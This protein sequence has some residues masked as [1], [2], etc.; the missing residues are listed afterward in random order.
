MDHDIRSCDT[1][2]MV[3]ST[4]VYC[5]TYHDTMLYYML[6][7]YIRYPIVRK[8]N[9]MVWGMTWCNFTQYHWYGMIYQCIPWHT[10][11]QG[12][13]VWYNV[14]LH[15]IMCY[16]LVC[17]SVT[18]KWTLMQYTMIWYILICDHRLHNHSSKHIMMQHNTL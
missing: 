5:G 2:A 15:C 18:W 6:W 7:H 16:E 9:A 1:T 4:I 10:T 11:S 8:L 12:H 17:S 3:W 13:V 14:A